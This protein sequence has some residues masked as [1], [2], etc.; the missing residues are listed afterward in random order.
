M[1]NG[2]IYAACGSPE[3]ILLLSYIYR[4]CA[5]EVIGRSGVTHIMRTNIRISV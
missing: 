5:K 1:T 2:G 4:A 3:L